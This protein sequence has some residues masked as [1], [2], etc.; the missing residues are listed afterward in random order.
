[1]AII[2]SPK[3]RSKYYAI[4]SALD[5]IGYNPCT[6]SSGADRAEPIGGRKP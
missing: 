5:L 4:Y 2:I 3:V 1:M 6:I